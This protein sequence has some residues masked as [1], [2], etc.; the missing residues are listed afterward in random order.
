MRFEFSSLRTS[1]EATP[2]QE[3][4]EAERGWPDDGGMDHC[5]GRACSSA[6]DRGVGP[7][8]AFRKEFHGWSL[9]LKTR[10]TGSSQG[11][12]CPSIEAVTVGRVLLASPN[13]FQPSL[14]R[15]PP[16][17]SSSLPLLARVSR[18]SVYSV[19]ELERLIGFT[20]PLKPTT[21]APAPFIR[22][23]AVESG[24]VDR[25]VATGAPAGWQ[26]EDVEL[27]PKA[28]SGPAAA[29]AAPSLVDACGFPRCWSQCS[30]PGYTRFEREVEWDASIA[31]DEA[32]FARLAQST[33]VKA[34]A[35][36]ALTQ[37]RLLNWAHESLKGF[38]PIHAPAPAPLPSPAP[39][40]SM[41]LA[42]FS[43]FPPPGP[44]GR[45][46][47]FSPS[48]QLASVLLNLDQPRAPA[49]APGPS[50]PA[51]SFVST[52]PAV[53]SSRKSGTPATKNAAQVSPMSQLART[54]S[55]KGKR[56]ASTA[57]LTD[58][59]GRTAKLAKS[60]EAKSPPRH[61]RLPAAAHVI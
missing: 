14:S 38:R 12:L 34:M 33:G 49:A 36:E 35:G 58:A 45:F 4:G 25:V 16:P 43:S 26:P 51:P 60:G 23:R 42:G 31:Q 24:L 9:G 3:R 48:H 2:H 19:A 5:R 18:M 10:A 28:A 21:D 54:A 32:D 59:N 13:H 20:L 11:E 61:Q 30:H 17:P 50:A 56:V 44:D 39:T 53:G 47:P 15:P 6:F 27:L 40:T 29:A 52:T 37:W 41:S 7:A 55:D 1:D 46:P 8:F 22:H 57:G